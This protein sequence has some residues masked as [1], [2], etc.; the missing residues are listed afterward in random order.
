M[1]DDDLAHDISELSDES[2]GCRDMRHAWDKKHAKWFDV[3]EGAGG[4]IAMARRIMKCRDCPVERTDSFSKYNFDIAAGV[5][6]HRYD[7]PPG[8]RFAPGVRATGP[9]IRAEAYRRQLELI[10][11]TKLTKRSGTSR[12]RRAS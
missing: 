10:E 11:G 12:S 4:H 6:P 8:Y 9:E 5:S 2:L 7:Y 1:R 3:V